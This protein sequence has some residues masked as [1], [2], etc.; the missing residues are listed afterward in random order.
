[1][2]LSPAQKQKRYRQRTRDGRIV[3]HVV[4]DHCLVVSALLRL[5]WLT[6]AQAQD[7]TKVEDLLA[8][9]IEGWGRE[10]ARY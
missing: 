9:V 7:R 6:E 3:A 2:S 10:L 1:M 4:V 5:G 8:E